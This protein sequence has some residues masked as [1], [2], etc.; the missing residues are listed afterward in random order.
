[1]SAVPAKSLP[2][3][4]SIR[5]VLEVNYS[6]KTLIEEELANNE[7]TPGWLCQ[8]CGEISEGTAEAPLYECGGCEKIFNRNQTDNG[9]HR[10]PDCNKFGSKLADDCCVSCE[11]GV[12]DAV[13]FVECPL[14][15]ELVEV[16]S[17]GEHVSTG[18][19]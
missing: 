16:E 17:L 1:M 19:R 8:E 10:C 15:G 13:V 5:L 7:A 12:V 3:P 4:V 18:C 11:T 6:D 2:R 9:D 14:C